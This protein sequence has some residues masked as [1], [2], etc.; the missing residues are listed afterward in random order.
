M[1]AD[2]HTRVP[3]E[4]ERAPSVVSP[5]LTMLLLVVPMVLMFLLLAHCLPLKE[6]EGHEKHAQAPT[7][8]GPRPYMATPH[9]GTCNKE[10]RGCGV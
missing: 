9:P 8:K 10:R 6:A 7:A 2:V 3:N 5:L 4:S 1:R